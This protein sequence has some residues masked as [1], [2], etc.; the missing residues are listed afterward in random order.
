MN[1]DS[2]VR[3]KPQFLS[4]K[5]KNKDKDGRT[6]IH[7]IQISWGEDGWSDDMYAPASEGKSMVFRS[8]RPNVVTY[9][10]I[11]KYPNNELKKFDLIEYT[12]ASETTYEGLVSFVNKYIPNE[13][14]IL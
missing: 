7:N 8:P 5:E 4:W 11:V 13:W 6:F 10:E 1:F 3:D 2:F 9:I 12:H 14:T